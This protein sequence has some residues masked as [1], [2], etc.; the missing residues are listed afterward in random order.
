MFFLVCFLLFKF[1]I[2]KVHIAMWSSYLWSFFFFNVP[3]ISSFIFVYSL[4]AFEF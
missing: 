3:F 1:D 4:F 2:E